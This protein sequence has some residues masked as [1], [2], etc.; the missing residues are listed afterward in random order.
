M[1]PANLQINLERIIQELIPK[2][3][4]ITE[5]A[6]KFVKTLCQELIQ[7]I[8][9]ESGFS[10]SISLKNLLTQDDVSKIIAKSGLSRYINELDEEVKRNHND[11][12]ELET[13]SKI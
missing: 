8:S 3:V 13:L 7:K 11:E 12:I 9:F 4:K 1:D 2:D 6:I 10:H 5:E